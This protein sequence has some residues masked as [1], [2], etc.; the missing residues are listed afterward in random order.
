MLNLR[1]ARP[2]DIE[3]IHQMERD[4]YEGFTCPQEMLNSWIR[5]LPEN[6]IVAEENGRM[7]GFVF[8]EYLDEIKALSFVHESE[9][10]KNGRFVY[11]SDVGIDDE[12]KNTDVLQ[13]LFDKLIEKSKND[14]CKTV[15]WLT[16]SKSAHDRIE[17]K[18]LEKN[19]FT[20]HENVKRWEAYPGLFVDDHFI[21]TK[22]IALF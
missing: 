13:K 21:W 7:A 15:V 8:F 22:E 9:H 10:K 14:G 16:G 4:Y 12:F 3:Q 6:F 17:S 2:Q 19:G 11:V 18:F 5:A 20:K 1:Q